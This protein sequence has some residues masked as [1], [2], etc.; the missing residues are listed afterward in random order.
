MQTKDLA[1]LTIHKLT[2]A[3]YERELSKGNIDE[4]ALY[5]TPD[6]AIDLS[7]YATI[8][9][10]HDERYYTEEEVDAAIAQKATLL[11]AEINARHIVIQSTDD[12]ID[13]LNVG[14]DWDE[15]WEAPAI[16]YGAEWDGSSSTTW[17]RTDA[18]ATFSNPSPAVANGTGSSPFDN[19]YPWNGMVRV[20]D[21]EAGELVAIP[22]FWYK[23]SVPESGSGLKLQI[24]NKAAAGFYVSPAHS[25]RG[26]GYGERDVVYVGRYHCGN[27]YKST[28]DVAQACWITRSTA[29]TGIA[30]LG[31]SVRQW[32]F[33][34]WRTIQMLYLVEFADW[35]SQAVIGYGCSERGS[36][37][38]NGAT[39][40]MQYHTGTTAASRTTYG[41]TQ[42]RNIEGLWDNIGD[43][44]DGVYN[45][46]D[47]INVIMNPANYSDT[48]NGATI[49]YPCGDWGFPSAMAISNVEGY[50]WAIYPSECNG[51][52]S[53]YV[54]DGWGF[55]SSYPCWVV[56]GLYSQYQDCGLFYAACL[57]ASDANGLVGCRLQKLPCGG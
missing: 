27:D 51:N 30:A 57:N 13:S 46:G 56:G 6:E 7:G 48:A 49:G 20:A 12:P 35:N 11:T 39:D 34:L 36:K 28:T 53:S 38:N 17:T 50:N 9:H 16:I 19:L 40:A 47:G 44:L 10:T 26:D 31:D 54:A 21:A 37:V 8:T 18:A 3:Q 5:L 4:Y 52:E 43:W 41:Y 29:R 42:Y 25:D 15:V 55:D 32:D 1:T 2:N 33:A 22:K 45:N 23:F 14:D 24:A